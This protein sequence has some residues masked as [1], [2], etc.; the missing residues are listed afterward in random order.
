MVIHRRSSAYTERGRKTPT[1]CSCGSVVCR[2]LVTDLKS[3]NGTFI[4]RFRVPPY[5]DQEAFP[6]K[7]SKADD[8]VPQNLTA[9]KLA[10]SL[11]P[12]TWYGVS[13]LAGSRVEVLAAGSQ[14]LH[15]GVVQLQHVLRGLCLQPELQMHRTHDTRL[16]LYPSDK[17]CR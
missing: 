10:G 16:S 13:L 7:P 8:L 14:A 6:G 9:T 1:V 15:C 17:T 12:A 2:C 5:V 4:N 3:L 11:W